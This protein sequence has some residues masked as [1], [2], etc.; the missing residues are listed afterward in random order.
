MTYNV[1]GYTL[2]SVFLV[3]LI[4]F[5]GVMSLSVR[6]DK[7]EKV[8]LYV[9]SFS[10]GALFGDVFIHLLPEMIEKSGFTLAAGLY[11]LAGILGSF[12]IEKVVRWKHHH[13][14]LCG[15]KSHH[16]QHHV[17][18][19]A[20]MNLIGDG[21]HNFLD[22]IIVGVS[23]VISLPA[24]IATTLA[25]IAHEIPQEMGDFGVLLHGGFSRSKALFFNF[26]SGLTA[27]LGAVVA[28]SLQSS[29]VN[30]NGVLIPIAIGGFIYIAGSDLIPELHRKNGFSESTWQVI[31]FVLGVL[32][33]MLLLLLG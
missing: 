26:I 14:H 11:I 21:V 19:F 3:S 6:K 22:G 17:R 29:I 30:I 24:G 12:I 7:L 18:P 5:V 4:S 28:L 16:T 8:L 10:A 13:H 20:V 15:H 2:V 23:Y 27:I 9:V 32:V 33:M 1:W 31:S 25:V